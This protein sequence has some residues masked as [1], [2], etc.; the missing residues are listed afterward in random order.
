M[1]LKEFIKELKRLSY[2]VDNPNKVEVQMADCIP[3]VKPVLKEGAVYITDI[4]PSTEE[5]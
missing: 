3:V 4:D 5:N 1:K 2:Q